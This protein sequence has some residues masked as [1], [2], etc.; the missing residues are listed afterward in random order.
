MAGVRKDTRWKMTPRQDLDK[1]G[2][3]YIQVLDMYRRGQRPVRIA[4]IYDFPRQ[5][6]G[7]RPAH[8]ANWKRIINPN[9]IIAG[10][11]NAHSPRWNPLCTTS[12]DH[13]FL[14]EL[15]DSYD[16]RYVGDGQETHWQSGQL[17]HSVIDLV[18][19][20]MELEEH[21]TCVR[22]D[23]PAHATPS[24]HEALWWEVRTESEPQDPAYTSRGWAVADWLADEE[25]MQAAEDEWKAT[26]ANHPTLD[27][28]STPADIEAE[29]IWIRTQLTAML[30]RHAKK[31]TIT[32]RSKRWWDDN[33]RTARTK[34][35]RLRR[36]RQ[37]RR[38][39]EPT[40]EEKEARN[41]FLSVTVL[42]SPRTNV[43]NR[44]ASLLEK[45]R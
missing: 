40:E 3:G 44:E 14:E 28:T 15:M 45:G 38:L 11:F 2:E 17:R 30:D 32:A 36:D 8:N 7:I 37:A 27:D 6:D 12:K 24:D 26:C 19:A 34:Y 33:I 18:M 4:N 41:S 10:D 31:I 25:K 13:L 39:R 1:D 35:G 29:A 22:V 16:L 42:L 43:G 20:T 5:S 9:T 21:T 23:D